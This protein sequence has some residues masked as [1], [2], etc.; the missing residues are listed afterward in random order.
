MRLFCLRGGFKI[1]TVL[2]QDGLNLVK[3]LWVEVQEGGYIFARTLAKSSVLLGKYQNVER[4]KEVLRD[5]FQT[6]Y[7]EMP[8]D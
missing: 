8:L 3:P 2:S 6:D 7:Y 4:A 5:I 1:G